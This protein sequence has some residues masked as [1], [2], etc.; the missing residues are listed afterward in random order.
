MEARLVGSDQP[1]SAQAVVGRRGPGVIRSVNSNLP[2]RLLV[3]LSARRTPRVFLLGKPSATNDA[4]IE[5]FSELGFSGAARPA[6]DASR[7]SAGDFVLGRLDVLPTLDGIEPGLWTLPGYARRGA[8]VLNGARAIFAAHDKLMTAL[9]LAGAGVD[10][11][12][13]SHTRESKLPAGIS[14]PYVVKP[15]HGSWGRDVYRCDSDEE[16]L[17]RLLELRERTW[18]KQHGALVQ[19]FIPC[20]GSDLRLIVAG[21]EIVGAVE[22]IARVGEWRTDVALGAIRRPIAPTECPLP[23]RSPGCSGAAA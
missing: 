1:V 17:E 18:F 19:E 14:A 6:I 8:V 16:L 10:H 22:R 20:G 7:F 4:L 12:R 15:R 23:S 3:G 5:A 11:P 13:T 2:A 21:S 9:L